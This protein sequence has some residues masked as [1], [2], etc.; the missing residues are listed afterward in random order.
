MAKTPTLR[1]I[2]GEFLKDFDPLLAEDQVPLNRRELRAAMVFAEEV[3][4]DVRGGTKSDPIGQPWFDSIHFEV[5]RWY[6]RRYG[7]AMH[8]NPDGA[9][10]GVVLLGGAPLS[11][12]FPLTIIGPG[13]EPANRRIHFPTRLRDDETA[14]TFLDANVSLRRFTKEERAKLKEDISSVIQDTRELNRA[15]RFA[16]LS[17]EGQQLANRAMWTIAHAVESIAAGTPDRRALAVW[18]LNL[19]AE[20]CLK[21]FLHG[22][23]VHPPKIHAV[24]SLHEKA[25]KAGLTPFDSAALMLFPSDHEAIRFRYGEEAAPGAANVTVLYRTALAL[26]LHATSQCKRKF[27]LEHDGWIEVR[28]IGALARGTAGSNRLIK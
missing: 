21:V 20:L 18:E 16:I 12:S 14:L 4:E 6:A 23:G 24:G 9:S 10:R 13:S 2:V 8:R 3:V 15:L 27:W 11:L 17:D 25:V 7:D 1:S 22:Q 5:L 28:T 19:L 26:A